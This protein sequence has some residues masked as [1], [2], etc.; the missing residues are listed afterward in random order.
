MYI[1]KYVYSIYD[2]GNSVASCKCTL[3]IIYIIHNIVS[4]SAKTKIRTSTSFFL[5]FFR[6]VSLSFSL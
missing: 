6:K 1:C 2:N 4:S 3:V 5:F